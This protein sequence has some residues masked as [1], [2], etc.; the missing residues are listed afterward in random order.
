[1]SRRDRHLSV[2][3]S[4]LPSQSCR[5]LPHTGCIAT[6][7]DVRQAGEDVV[8]GSMDTCIESTSTLLEEGGRERG[9][10]GGEREGG[11]ERERERWRKG[12]GRVNIMWW[13]EGI[14]PLV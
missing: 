5:L 6:V 12:L 13:G 10:E 11:R 3:L 14:L 9:R 8:I 1:M 2:V 4:T 7:S